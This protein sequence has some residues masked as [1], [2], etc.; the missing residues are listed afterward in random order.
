MAVII[1]IKMLSFIGNGR[2][3]TNIAIAAP[4]AATQGATN[5]LPAK[6]RK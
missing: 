1:G 6:K 3:S 5:K 2:H 4:M